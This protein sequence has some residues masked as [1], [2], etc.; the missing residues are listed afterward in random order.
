MPV[1]IAKLYGGGGM[2]L[3]GTPIQRDYMLDPRRAL[4]LELMKTGTSTAPVQSPMEGLARALTAGLGGYFGH[5][6]RQEM[7]G[8]E[9]SR[10][11]TMAEALGAL[12]GPTVEAQGPVQPGME[13]PTMK[14]PGDVSKA[15]STLAGN[16]DLA[17]T[18]AQWQ[19]ADMARGQ[20]LEEKAAE[21]AW[22]EQQ[23]EV[24]FGRKKDL[25]TFETGLKNQPLSPEMEAQKKRLIE[26]ARRQPEKPMPAGIVKEQKEDME[27]AG[28]ADTLANTMESWGQKIEKGELDLGTVKN[29]L[30]RGMSYLSNNDPKATQYAD[31]VAEMN[32]MRND[33]LRLNKGTQTEGDAIRAWDELIANLN[34]PHIVKNRLSKIA[35][36]NR[37]SSQLK[38]QNIDVMRAEYGK[39]PMDW[40]KY[41]RAQSGANEQAQQAQPSDGWGARPI[42]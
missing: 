26:A 16:P 13:A 33:T 25:A 3:G 41:G 30:N 11:K 31:F 4:M 27:A 20:S 29:I 32:K 42:P 2:A 24:E 28:L 19:L 38:K 40:S 1:N 8:R 17:D 35:G 23:M 22:K 18:A 15:V 7:Q 21:R 12:R 39:E 10:R 34:N 36:Y 5:Q 14:M 37:Q 6:A 9:E